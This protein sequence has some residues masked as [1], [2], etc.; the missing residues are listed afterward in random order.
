LD[1]LNEA[2]RKRPSG[3]AR[4]FRGQVRFY[5]AQET[6]D[7]ADLEAAQADAE[8]ANVLLLGNPVAV[9]LSLNVHM[10]AADFYEEHQDLERRDR[11]R[12]D[13]G[14][15]AAMLEKYPQCSEAF[16][17]RVSYL[18][19]FTN[20][21]A[22]V[23]E[24]RRANAVAKNNFGPYYLA[25]GL[26]RL[27]QIREA[28]D[29]LSHQTVTSSPWQN[30]LRCYILAEL[31]DGTGRA[32]E[33]F[34]EAWQS[35]ASLMDAL[36]FQSGLRF[37]GRRPEAVEL[38][39][40]LQEQAAS[41]PPVR[42]HWYNHLLDYNS[43][44]ISAETLLEQAGSSRWNRSEAHFHI[45]LNRLADGDRAGARQHFRQTTSKGAFNSLDFDWSRAFLARLEQDPNWPPWIPVKHEP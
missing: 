5:R 27:G 29:A 16:I 1:S 15:A 14:A 30:F 39:R 42:N 2:V 33:E 44:R 19:Q 17:A 25:L 21:L 22:L 6:G 45:G 3:T 12:R 11:A 31:P 32:L 38:S 43:E 24:L 8:A 13:A 34:H 18:K 41:L 26:Y 7:L 20:D 28:S 10:V 36:F 4:L 35:N 37:L 40:K 23:A 9:A